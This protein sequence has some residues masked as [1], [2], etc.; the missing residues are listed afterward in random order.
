M[1]AS[2]SRILGL[3]AVVERGDEFDRGL[4][5]FEV[6][7]ELGLDGASSIFSPR[8]GLHCK[9]ASGSR[10]AGLGAEIPPPSEGGGLKAV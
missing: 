3:G 4:E 1:S 7:L 10:S 5:L 2:S 8:L 6:G 9:G